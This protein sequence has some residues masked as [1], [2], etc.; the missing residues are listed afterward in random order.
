M[1]RRKRET[2]DFSA[3]V[4]AHLQLESE[5]LREQGLSEDE[6]KAKARRSFGNVLQA[7]ERFYEA[8]R[9]LAWDHFC[10]DLRYGLRMLRKA[11]GFTA[12]AI[13]TMALGIGATTAIFSVVD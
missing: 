7:E 1:F 5:R 13:L 11:P 3:E 9:W 6:A 2:K 10:Q 12:I 4:E 8:G